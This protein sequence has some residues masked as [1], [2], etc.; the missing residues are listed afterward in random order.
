MSAEDGNNSI[1]MEDNSKENNNDVE[2]RNEENDDDSSSEVIGDEVRRE[3]ISEFFSSQWRNLVGLQKCKKCQAERNMEEGNLF[4]KCG[5]C[6]DYS[7]CNSCYELSLNEPV[8]E[9]GHFFLRLT[10]HHSLG[11]FFFA[12]QKN[13]FLKFSSHKGSTSRN[14]R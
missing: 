9:K 2:M 4:W 10:H 12:S 7:L 8:H 5:Q 14:F 13:N 1:D 11:D 6:N 3:T